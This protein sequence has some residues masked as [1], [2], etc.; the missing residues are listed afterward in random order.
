MLR[1]VRAELRP[2]A[3]GR[4][5]VPLAAPY[6]TTLRHLEVRRDLEALQLAEENDSQI[7]D[8]GCQMKECIPESP[9]LERG[10]GRIEQ[11]EGSRW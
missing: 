5:R 8:M 2:F 11:P 9:K 7:K 10:N 1:L 3:R 4:Y 6:A